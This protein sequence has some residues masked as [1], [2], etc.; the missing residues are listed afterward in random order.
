M[1][2]THGLLPGLL[3]TIGAC[4]RS[5]SPDARDERGPLPTQERQGRQERVR[6][7]PT[8]PRADRESVLGANDR[9]TGESRACEVVVDPG[10]SPPVTVRELA[11]V[12]VGT[13]THPEIHGEV[14]FVE[15]DDGAWVQSR[16]TG[17]SDGL[18]AHHVH[19][20]G[21][22]SDPGRTAGPP[23]DFRRPLLDG[24]PPARIPG[25]LGDL[26][27]R[28]GEEAAVDETIPGLRPTEAAWTLIGRSI[29]IHAG[30]DDPGLP[31]GG[32]GEPIACGV[33]GIVGTR[34]ETP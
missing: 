18:H 3:V 9:P 27:G 34:S 5:P 32:A 19:R 15:T 11:A 17:L 28:N 1:H 33:I 23:F 31:D 22:C 30:P 26:A 20:F 6:V 24:G 4:G 13:A 21:D 7:F 2:L 10:A 29:V 14:R 8:R 16:V 25:D 12:V